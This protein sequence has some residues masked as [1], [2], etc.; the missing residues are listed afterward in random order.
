MRTIQI[1]PWKSEWRDYFLHEQKL[2][3]LET[4]EAENNIFHIGS[5]SVPGL[6]AKPIIDILIETSDLSWWIMDRLEGLGYTGKGE[7]GIAG[8]AFYY[9]GKQVRRFHVHVFEKKSDGSGRHLA[10]RDYLR[11]F[12]TKAKEYECIKKQAAAQY[13]HS[14]SEYM[15]EKQIVV[16]KLEQ[17]ALCWKR[18]E[19]EN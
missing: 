6:A 7:H 9:K 5:T 8:R 14:P 18:A 11:S 10:L 13:P 12:P 19:E 1:V 3:E 2:L 16:Q 15:N 17:E 4:G